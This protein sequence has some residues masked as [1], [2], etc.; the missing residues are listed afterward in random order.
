MKK[1]FTIKTLLSVV[2][3]LAFN[4]LLVS[5]LMLVIYDPSVDAVAVKDF[6]MDVTL[7]VNILLL[8]V[9]LLKH[10]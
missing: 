3:Y 10:R 6:W 4:L 1:L 8:T 7:G 9:T 2:F 5:I